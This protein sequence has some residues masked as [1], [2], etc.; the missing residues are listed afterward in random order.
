MIQYLGWI[1]WFV[2]VLGVLVTFHEY[3]HFFVAR[4]C[5]VRVQ[6][7]S[8]GFGRALWSRIGRD[9]TEYRIAAI[10]LGGYVKFLDGRESEFP[11]TAA[12]QR[13]AFDTQP[14]WK[15]I[16]IALAGPLANLLLCIV[17]LW[18]ALQVGVPETAPIVGEAT[19]LAAE[20]GF[21]PGDRLESID[22]ASAPTWDQAVVPLV[23]AAIDH[24]NVVVGVRDASGAL[25][26]RRLELARLPADFDQTRPFQ[27]IGLRPSATQ[28]R[29]L[30]GG[31]SD[32][33]A[34]K[35]V[36]EP[37]DLIVA[38]EGHPI[39]RYSDIGPR[40]KTEAAPGKSLRI[41]V[42]RGERL[43]HVAVTPK[44]LDS[45]TPHRWVLGVKPTPLEPVVFRF[46]AAPAFGETLRRTAI[47]TRTTFAVL[48]RLVIGRASSSNVSGAIGIA[49]AADS[50]AKVGPGGFLSFMASLS[51]MLCIMNLM[52]IPVLDGGHLLYYL[53]EL[54]T[55]RLPSERVQIAGQF[56]GL[57]LIVG[58]ISLAL[59]NDIHRLAS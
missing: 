18:I 20:A 51:L 50:A 2:V 54:A 14:V 3:G 10:P 4:R 56:V 41:D 44:W 23:L 55:G 21:A 42:R 39:A 47:M 5:G 36:L 28:D 7:F 43:L 25:R 49:E 1:F 19:G 53:I 45:E 38:I 26:E 27:A 34:A 31:L 59:Y 6:R 13:E 33:A 30:V 40:L 32:D 29:P 57:A 17:L 35:G 58:L 48:K 8:V 24:R 12:E 52:P 46:A 22:G 9:G 16:V 15:R 11:L 37:G